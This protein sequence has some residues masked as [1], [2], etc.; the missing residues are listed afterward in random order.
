MLPT[1]TASPQEVQ[2]KAPQGCAGLGSR[3]LAN[4]L[5]DTCG[6]PG[7]APEEMLGAKE[8]GEDDALLTKKLWQH[9]HSCQ[10]NY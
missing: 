5:A 2:D 1:L 10:E 9:T 6:P 8:G 4:N 7:S 3:L